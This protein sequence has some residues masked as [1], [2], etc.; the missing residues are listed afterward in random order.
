[1]N[2][3]LGLGTETRTEQE[4]TIIVIFAQNLKHFVGYIF[5]LWSQKSKTKIYIYIIKIM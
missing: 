5:V 4:L 1:M 2:K 3:N